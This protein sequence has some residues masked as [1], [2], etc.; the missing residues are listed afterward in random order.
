MDKTIKPGGNFFA[1]V[2]GTWVKNAV[3]PPDG[4]GDRPGEERFFLAYAQACGA[5]SARALCAGSYSPMFT[6]RTPIG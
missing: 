2:N 5:R 3:I 6:R 1:F 4:A